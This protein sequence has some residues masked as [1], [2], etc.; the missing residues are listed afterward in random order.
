MDN[1]FMKLRKA[2]FGGFNRQDVIAYI[3]KVKNE[4]YE[5]KSR[6]QKQVRELTEKIGDLEAQVSAFDEEKDKLVKRIGELSVS[7]EGKNETV[8]E[9]NEATNHLKNVADE[10]CRSL[11]DFMQRISENC[12]SVVI[13]GEES[14]AEDEFDGEKFIAELEAEIYAKLGVE[15]QEEESCEEDAA[16]AGEPVCAEAS[17][18]KDK[19]L[20]ILSSVSAFSSGEVQKNENEKKTEKDN[21]VSAILGS[22]SFL[23]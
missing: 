3:E 20:S 7:G 22:L 2:T 8:E 6:L 9:I 16:D 10:L 23:K 21:A 13:E 18:N 12:C 15:E 5:E 14:D 19:V 11:R 17:E 4:A 1:N